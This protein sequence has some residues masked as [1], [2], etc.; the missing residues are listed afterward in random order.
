VAHLADDELV[1]EHRIRLILSEPDIAIQAFDQEA[2]ALIGRY[3]QIEPRCRL[4]FSDRYGRRPLGFGTRS[5]PRSGTAPGY[6]R[7]WV[8]SPCRT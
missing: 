6:T 5:L 1:G 7:N 3:A 4:R 2:W 8:V